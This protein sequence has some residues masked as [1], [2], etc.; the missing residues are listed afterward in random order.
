MLE[1]TNPLDSEARREAEIVRQVRENE[2]DIEPSRSSIMESPPLMPLNNSD[3][4]GIGS[5]DN[6]LL[7]DEPCQQSTKGI[8]A[9]FPLQ[10]SRGFGGKEFWNNYNSRM[11]TPPPPFMPQ[12]SSSAMSD[13]IS[14]DSPSM[15]AS[16]AS[17]LSN[18][19]KMGR[20]SR[21]ST[22]QLQVLPTVADVAKK[23][24]KRRRDD[25]F[26][27]ASFKRRAVS[28][29][30]SAQNSP[31][32]AQSPVQRDGG[33][34]STAKS[35]RESSSA[36]QGRGERSGSTGSL[37]SMSQNP[38]PKRVGMQGITDTHD[39]LMKMSIE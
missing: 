36:G 39:G 28:P 18:Q 5:E 12:G 38:G 16:S 22:P 11:K 7:S 13:D 14:I 27:L 10:A 4:P 17:F 31:V 26:D 34:W 15:S 24:S 37:T 23:M 32:V 3:I 33:F 29:G 25:D 6:P 1:E 2:T 9:S 21:S 19:A 35:S 30:M 20:G 8:F